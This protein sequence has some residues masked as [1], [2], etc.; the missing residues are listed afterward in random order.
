MNADGKPDVYVANDTDNNFLFANRGSAGAL[1]LEELGLLAGV[2]VDDRG[3]A[4]GSMGVDAGDFDRTGRPSIIVTN[5]EN[6][7]PAL[8]EN[9]TARG[10]AESF[11]HVT[12]PAGLAVVGGRYVSWGTGFC[13]FD[14]DGWEDLYIVSGHAIRFPT[15]LD[16]RQKPNL[17]KNTGGRFKVVSR[18]GGPYFEASHNARGSAVGD[19]DNDGRPDMV[20][21]HLN[22]PV[23]VLRNVAP[24]D[25]RHWVGFDLVGKN[26][27]SVVGARVT[28][29][30]AAGTLTRFVKGGGS[31]ASTGDRRLH[32]GLG[33][34]SAI[35]KVTVHWP[36]GSAQEFTAPTAD[37][38]W[39]LAEGEA[40][41]R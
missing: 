40:S 35:K 25:G 3:M 32:F 8:Y 6:E 11:A 19:L 22:E 20:V 37:R 10:G 26:H 21:C 30:T 9:R 18:D 24:T 5:Y 7:L 1:R 38:Y 13:D 31:F 16:R 29:E 34:D 27:R 12:Q 14:L 15:K 36:W 41:A 4:N 39:V 17:F 23:V 28:V 33:S 2:A